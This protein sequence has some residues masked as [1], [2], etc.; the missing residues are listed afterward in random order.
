MLLIS[1]SWHGVDKIDKSAWTIVYPS[2]LY[3]KRTVNMPDICRS[4]N[5]RLQYCKR[6][7]GTAHNCMDTWV[8]LFW[9]LF[10]Q[11]S[12]CCGLRN[13]PVKKKKKTAHLVSDVNLHYTCYFNWK[14]I[15]S[16]VWCGVIFEVF[17]SLFI[18]LSII[19]LFNLQYTLNAVSTT[20]EKGKPKNEEKQTPRSSLIRL[21]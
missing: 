8:E 7:E 5:I 18:K 14:F 3:I 10:V 21:K 11:T 6:S 16:V 17:Q 12:E 1:S 13:M 2:L 9:C 19:G 4:F 20:N 15:L